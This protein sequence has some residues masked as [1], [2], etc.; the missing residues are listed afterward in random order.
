[1]ATMHALA[2][3]LRDAHIGGAKAPS[4]YAPQDEVWDR[5]KALRIRPGEDADMI[6][7]SGTRN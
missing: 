1:M 5:F 6:R 7:T 3:I 2:A 4:I